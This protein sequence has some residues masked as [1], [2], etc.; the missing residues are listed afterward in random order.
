MLR[1]Q[2][3]EHFTRTT[4]APHGLASSHLDVEERRAGPGARLTCSEEPI[5]SHCGCPPQGPLPA[6]AD[7][8]VTCSKESWLCLKLVLGL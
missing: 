8:A 4:S 3:T 7:P 6:S 2:G 1:L 5:G